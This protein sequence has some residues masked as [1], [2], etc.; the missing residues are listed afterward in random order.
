MKPKAIAGVTA[1]ALSVAAYYGST[2]SST[3]N[4]ISTKDSPLSRK[5]DTAARLSLTTNNS[6]ATPNNRS[7]TL[8]D[9][10]VSKQP[11]VLPLPYAP[12]NYKWDGRHPVDTPKMGGEVGDG[13]ASAK[14]SSSPAAD[15][16]TA[17]RHLFLI[18]HGQYFTEKILEEDRKLTELGREQLDLT[19]AR[20]RELG[21]CFD[22][23]VASTMTRA[24]ESASIV[25]KHFPDLC[26]ECEPLLEE[27]AP[28]KPEPPISNWSPTEAQF[29]EDGERIEA[30]F[31]KYFHRATPEMKKDS[32]EII[33]CHG[34]VI[35][36][37]VCRALQ[38]PPEAW[39]RMGLSHGSITWVSVKP[40]GR[41]TLNSLGVNGHMPP[42]KISS[43]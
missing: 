17:T 32:Y 16:P 11:R 14:C 23:L 40:S 43:V 4:D 22:R 35:R 29:R 8:A 13:D 1:T 7:L 37:C 15:I 26:L 42:K 38:I 24:Q 34:N 19:G 2:L 36:Y 5:D 41:V 20:L 31:K 39:L 21:L 10:F 12:W 28:V 18:R 9:S 25:H 3:L 6:F 30:A 33:V 27:G